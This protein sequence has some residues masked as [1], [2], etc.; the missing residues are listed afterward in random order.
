MS[1]E[2]LI[3]RH[4]EYLYSGLNDIIRIATCERNV[5][6]SDLCIGRLRRHMEGLRI[7]I[8]EQLLKKKSRPF[9]KIVCFYFVNSRIVPI[10][11]TQQA[12]WEPLEAKN[13]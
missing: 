13:T 9:V 6:M 10:F 3:K 7:I 11:A 2:E 12:M 5:A 4:K 8:S 1:K